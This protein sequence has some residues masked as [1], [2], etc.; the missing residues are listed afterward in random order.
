MSVTGNNLPKALYLFDAAGKPIS[1]A[2]KA[3][4]LAANWALTWY[5]A[6][7]V[8]LSTQPTWSLGAGDARGRHLVTY[9]LP[10]GPWT[11]R[12]STPSDLHT[13]APIEFD[14]EG[15]SY[16]ADSLGGLLAASAGVVVNTT[17]VGSQ[18][19]IFHGDSIQLD[20]AVLE[21]ALAYIG[22]SDLASCTLSA[23]IK[24][25]SNDTEDAQDATLSCAILA[26][27]S[28]NRVVRAT[29]NT[30]P[31]ALAPPTGGQQTQSAKA[32]LR[33]VNTGTTARTVIASQYD[34]TVKWK[35]TTA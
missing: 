20:F 28:G 18:T 2:T 6:L 9:A 8:A 21:A 17:L 25:N 31:A 12:V 35:A 10:D 24:L 23:G 14:G 22:V 5:D 16:D 33:L 13:S 7:G 11:A 4:F 1:F 19:E 29:L 30:F 26:D 3:A 32:H 34:I 15:S 27:T